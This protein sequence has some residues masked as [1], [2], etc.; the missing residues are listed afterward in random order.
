MAKNTTTNTVDFLFN[1]TIFSIDS[2]LGCDP[3]RV[4]NKPLNDCWCRF[5]TG[6]MPFLSSSQTSGVK[7]PKLINSSK[8]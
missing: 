3:P 7:S 1:Q 4:W 6:Q 2:T 8:E 5:V